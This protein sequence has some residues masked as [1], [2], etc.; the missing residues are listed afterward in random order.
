M[1]FLHVKISIKVKARGLVIMTRVYL[2]RDER[3]YVG[4]N[5]IIH[6][7]ERVAMGQHHSVH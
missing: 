4:R 7:T 2:I 5:G 3:G 1:G 6:L